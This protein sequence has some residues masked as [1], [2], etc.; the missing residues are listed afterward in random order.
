MGTDKIAHLNLSPNSIN[1]TV[2]KG[3]VKIFHADSAG[4]F[5][6]GLDGA[7]FPDT[8]KTVTLNL[9][10]RYVAQYH[11]HYHQVDPFLK[12]IPGANSY[13]D[14]DLMPPA[15]FRRLEW[16]NDFLKIQNQHHQLELYLQYDRQLF[17]YIGIL[18]NDIKADFSKKDLNKARFLA[19]LLA[20]KLRR[21]QLNENINGLEK[22]L[23]Q[24]CDLSNE[25]IILTSGFCPIYW[26]ARAEE[27]GLSLSKE[28]KKSRYIDDYWPLLPPEVTREC[29]RLGKYI[30]VSEDGS[31]S[32]NRSISLY[33]GRNPE[34]KVQIKALP[35][36]QYSAKTTQIPPIF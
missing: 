20:L 10:P 34:L 5:S 24:I 15:D 32:S 31:D 36:L 6:S 3:L 26:N 21:S 7:S 29:I 19:R 13:R 30:Q 25:G 35:P 4:F 9:D 23:K 1:G 22:L 17:G 11:E 18:R 33:V 8:Q 14:P 16:Y 27:I 2:L 28:R 12:I